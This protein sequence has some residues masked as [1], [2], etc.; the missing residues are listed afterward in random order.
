METELASGCL[1]REGFEIGKL[2]IKFA[3]H[4]ENTKARE[5]PSAIVKT[6]KATFLLF[7]SMFYNLRLK[8]APPIFCKDENALLIFRSYCIFAD[9][10]LLSIYCVF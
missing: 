8:D 1:C 3:L 10:Q 6:E 4:F 7:V 2:E 9:T 5:Y